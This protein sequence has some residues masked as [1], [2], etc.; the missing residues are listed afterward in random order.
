VAIDES[1]CHCA[2]V[3][4]CADDK[5][6]DKEEGLEV[7]E[8]RLDGGYRLNVIQGAWRT[9]CLGLFAPVLQACSKPSGLDFPPPIRTP[10]LESVTPC[11]RLGHEMLNF[12][13]VYGV[14][15]CITCSEVGPSILVSLAPG[16]L[17]NPFFF[18]AR[19]KGAQNMPR[20]PCNAITGLNNCIEGMSDLVQLHCDEFEDKNNLRRPSVAL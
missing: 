20:L 7:E 6:N 2:D 14:C 18:F 11:L 10:F 17:R 9:I 16:I 12:L 13:K 8:R 15:N 5:E 3:G 1:R 4:A 19:R